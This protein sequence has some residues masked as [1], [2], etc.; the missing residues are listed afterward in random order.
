MSKKGL[1]Q[2]S[3]RLMGDKELVAKLV[4]VIL[5]ALESSGFDFTAPREYPMYKDKKKRKEID[6]NRSRIYMTVYGSV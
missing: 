5:K 4:P 2:A 1:P 3:I 6:P